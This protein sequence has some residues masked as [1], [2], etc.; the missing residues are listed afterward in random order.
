[1]NHTWKIHNLKRI[2]GSGLVT[3]IS[4]ACESELSGSQSRRVG[5]IYI[6]GSE[7]D[8][9]FIQFNDLTEGDILGWVTSSIDTSAVEAMTS[10]SIAKDLSILDSDLEIEGTPWEG[11]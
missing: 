2:N 9:N 4:Y 6:T 10:A 5:T 7:S 3:E 8:P 11:N 1:M